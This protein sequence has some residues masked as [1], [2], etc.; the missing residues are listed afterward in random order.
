MFKVEYFEPNLVLVSDNTEAY[1][2]LNKECIG[3]FIEFPSSPYAIAI[4]NIFLFL[5]V[6]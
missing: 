4:R 6:L 5:K 2:K 1:L 3:L